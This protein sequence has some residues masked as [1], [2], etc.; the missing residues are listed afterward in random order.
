MEPFSTVGGSPTGKYC[1]TMMS[2]NLDRVVQACASDLRKI[3]TPLEL[4]TWGSRAVSR[5]AAGSRSRRI[6]PSLQR[7]TRVDCKQLY[8]AAIPHQKTRTFF[9]NTRSID[10]N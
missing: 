5:K 4:P 10:L 1:T 6:K 2:S 8:A 3:P 7:P 9:F